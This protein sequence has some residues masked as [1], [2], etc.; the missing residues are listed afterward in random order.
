MKTKILLLCILGLGLI[1]LQPAIFE[2]ASASAPGPAPAPRV[3]DPPA[4][5]RP[6]AAR[7]AYMRSATPQVAGLTFTVNR[8][9]D[10][11]DAQIGDGVCETGNGCTLRAAI[12]EANS[13]AGRDTINF[14]VDAA[15]PISISL[16]SPL[17]QITSPILI[18]G[19]SQL[20]YAGTPVIELNGGN[21]AGAGLDISAG[22]SEVLALAINRF[23]GAGIIL[24]DTGES[25]VSGCF[26]GTDPTGNI[27]LPNGSGINIIDSSGNFIGGA[28][29][30]Q[31]NVI[32]GNTGAGI[33]FLQDQSVFNT[34]IGNFIGTDAAGTSPLGNGADGIS[35]GGSSNQI[36]SPFIDEGNVISANLNGVTLT[37][38]ANEN[39]IQ[40]NFIG[41]DAGG[42]ADLGNQM[43]GISVAGSGNIIG[44]SPGDAPRSTDSGVH[45][46]GLPA[47]PRNIIAFNG[48]DGVAVISGINNSILA[49]SIFSNSLLGIDLGSDGVTPNDAGDPDAGPNNL[50][51]FPVLT[52]ASATSDEVT[53]DG[54][55]NSKPNS[56]YRL[57]FYTNTACDAS[58]FGEGQRFL[59]TRDVVTNADG[60]AT[61]SETLG[62][63]VAQGS[64]IT[65]TAT[66][67]LGNTSE[68]SQ[69]AL[70]GEPVVITDVAVNKTASPNPVPSGSNLTYT[71]TV[72][73]ISNATAEGVVV[74]DQLPAGTTF[75]SLASPGNCM[76]PPVG[77][78]GQVTCALG[79]L[80]P[81]SQAVLTLVV[82]VT[83]AQQAT[84]TNTVGVTTTSN[85][86]NPDNNSSTTMTPVIAAL[87]C[88]IECPPDQVVNVSAKQCGAAVAYPAPQVTDCGAVTCTPPSGSTFPV[89]L[90]TVT[91][92]TFAGP[93]CSFDVTVVDNIPPTIDCPGSIVIKPPQGASSAVVSFP[94]PT[95]TDNCPG[96]T[97][98]C[99]PPAGASFPPGVTTVI[100]V[101]TDAAFNGKSCSFTV[102]VDNQAP[103]ISCPQ[104]LT[105]QLAGSGCST[106]INYP[107]PVVADNQPGVAVACSPPSGSIFP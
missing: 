91:C 102:T 104:N 23:S 94:A 35:V 79:S 72:N 38:T 12:Q 18:D 55:I 82:K 24:R 11:P 59:G 8:A 13:Q 105:V 9:G 65:A 52:S 99:Q 49:N 28:A 101:A 70:V 83:A 26:I 86:G 78:T 50:Q 36:G 66:D 96:A 90:T 80:A 43:F 37:A 77:G 107:T 46:Q 2:R 25:I 56:T 62:G 39:V 17:P 64:A 3:Q 45:P 40:G 48:D 103:S 20:G 85:D 33:G 6:A 44:E 61:F 58:G 51:N 7:L 88:T 76:A 63:V 67:I 42:T 53:V 22:S 5:P 54:S 92:T 1:A 31:R 60:V 87:D 29:P 4:R 10:G 81:N 84:I 57:D 89:G 30:G 14:A 74:S 75:V 32:S 106:T 16:A 27:A 97:V 41:T 100:C 98:Q 73:N 95:V 93:A 34:V 71:I 69:C 47:T 15:L 19:T 68:F 21:L